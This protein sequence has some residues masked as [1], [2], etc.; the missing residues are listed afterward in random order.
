MQPRRLLTILRF[1]FAEATPGQEPNQSVCLSVCPSACLY[2][3]VSLCALVFTMCF[4]CFIRLSIMCALLQCVLKFGNQ[5]REAEE[6]DNN[7]QH[8][9]KRN[10]IT[11]QQGLWCRIRMGRS[12]CF[13][14]ESYACADKRLSC[15]FDMPEAYAM[16]SGSQ[17]YLC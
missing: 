7:K 3:S 2:A 1:C 14:L 16:H 6:N 10:S 4:W 17:S 11:T 8:D 9:V 15:S 12:G 13:E 5:D